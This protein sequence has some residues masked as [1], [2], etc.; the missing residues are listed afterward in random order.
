M[1]C[2][3]NWSTTNGK[4]P[5]YHIEPKERGRERNSRFDFV[6]ARNSDMNGYAEERDGQDGVNDS[7]SRTMLR[8]Q[9]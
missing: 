2:L 1:R 5:R 9:L 6:L 8:V 7:H 3:G 4:A